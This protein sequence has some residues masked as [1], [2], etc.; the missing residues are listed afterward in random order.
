MKIVL[1]DNEVKNIVCAW[2]VER[3]HANRDEIQEL[4]MVV[5][6]ENKS[7]EFELIFK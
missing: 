1:T 7:L 5:D 6:V 3:G 4:K 2:M